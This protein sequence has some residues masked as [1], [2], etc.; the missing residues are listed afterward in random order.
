[1]ILLF[2]ENKFVK[3]KLYLLSNAKKFFSSKVLI[4][5]YFLLIKISFKNLKDYKI[6]FT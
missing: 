1:M 3:L 2:F 4:S 5:F 6:K